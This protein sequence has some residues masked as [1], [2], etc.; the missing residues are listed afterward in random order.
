VAQSAPS[1]LHRRLTANWAAGPDYAFLQHTGKPRAHGTARS[2]PRNQER[3]IGRF[4][5]TTDRS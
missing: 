2:N 3:L 1:G 5:K 4:V